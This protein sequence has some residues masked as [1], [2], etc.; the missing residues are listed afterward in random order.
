[1]QIPCLCIGCKPL[2][3]NDE[4]TCQ[5]LANQEDML[6]YYCREDQKRNGIYPSI[7]DPSILKEIFND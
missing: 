4:P 2:A 1:M 7:I 5:F 6:C 3:Q